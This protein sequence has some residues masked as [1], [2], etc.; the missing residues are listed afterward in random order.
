MSQESIN[1]ALQKTLFSPMTHDDLWS[2]FLEAFSYEINNMRNKYG[3]IKENWSI[4][5]F[6]KEDLI[7]IAQSFGYDPNLIIDNTFFMTKKEIESIPY[8]IREKTTY[9]GYALIFHQNGLLGDTFNY[10]YNGEKL[11]KSIDYDATVKNLINSNHYSPFIGI[12][13]I[14]NFS[15]MINSRVVM[16]D[17]IDNRGEYLPKDS[18]G[19]PT[20]SLDQKFNPFWKLDSS[21][22]KIPTKHLGIEYY[23][24]DWKSN[25][26]VTLG[27]GNEDTS[28]YSCFISSYE[29]YLKNSMEIFIDNKKL[30]ITIINID[31]KEYFYDDL[32]I[33]DSDNSYYDYSNGEVILT[34]NEIPKGL[35]INI[36][37]DLDL[38]VTQDYFY[39]LENGMEYNRRC[40]IIPHSGVFLTADIS[41]GKGSDFYK[42]N[43]EGYTV[44]DLKLKAQ[45]TSSY[46]REISL[47]ETSKLD[48]AMDADGNPSGL[49][50]YKLDSSIKWFLD[51]EILSEEEVANKIK[52]IACGNGKLPMINDEFNQMFNQR[53]L[54]A[55][56]NFNT[57]DNDSLIRDASTNKNNCVVVGN[58]T[59]IDGIINKSLD[60]NGSTYCYSQ[61]NLVITENTNYTLGIWFN[62]NKEP[63]TLEETIFDNFY[64]IEYDYANEQ[65]I[66]DDNSFSCSKNTNHFLCLLMNYS[67]QTT[68]VY[69]DCNLVGQFTYISSLVSDILYIGCDNTQNNCFYGIIDNVWLIINNLTLNQ[70]EYIYN[71]KI[72][73]ISHMGNRLGYYEI[74]S[75]EIFNNSDYM[76]IQSYVK[77]MDITNETYNIPNSEDDIISSQTRFYPIIE[78]YYSFTYK[79]TALKDVKVESNIEGQFYRTDTNEMLSGKI[80]FENGTWSLD[81]NTIKSKSQLEIDSPTITPYPNAWKV[82]DENTHDSTWY[83]EYDPYSSESFVDKII[84]ADEINSSQS[85]MIDKVYC[86]SLGGQ[87]IY[88]KDEEN[89][90]VY[91]NNIAYNLSSFFFNSDANETPLYS[92][93]DGN[94]VYV[95][96]SDLISETNQLKTFVDLGEATGTT[97][98]S[99][100]NGT[101]MYLNVEC[102]QDKQIKKYSGHIN[103]VVTFGYTLGTTLDKYYS[104]LSFTSEITFSDEP[105]STSFTPN[106]ITLRKSPLEIKENKNLNLQKTT[107]KYDEVSAIDYIYDFSK[108]ETHVPD[109]S[110][111]IVKGSITFNY[112]MNNSEGAIIKHTATVSEEGSISGANI[113]TNLSSFDYDTNVLTVK[114]INPINSKVVTS[115]EFYHSLDINTS[116][117]ITMNYKTEKSIKINEIGIEDE[118][119]ELI[120]YMTFN[121]IEFHSIYNNISA[122][123]AINKK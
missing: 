68:S 30:S 42:R 16:L 20:Y 17:Y 29:Y 35:E 82:T 73:L 109:P 31:N 81:K 41:Q 18:Y 100:N 84:H 51:S 15:T 25:Y 108:D 21:Y 80:D 98:Y 90:Y 39:Y 55:Y 40:P 47:S 111:E 32:N 28:V 99:K 27:I 22:I 88:S 83:S 117:P 61:S 6:D 7:R 116:Y 9:N 85:V 49:D 58:T 87:N 122:M 86:Y 96:M 62:A 44:P 70:M 10:Y 71:N 26:S 78:G 56:Y 46:N 110:I 59:K 115:Y 38:F 3:E 45:T 43:E 114:F 104:D 52:Y 107:E 76:I 33:L 103:D 112:W 74:A 123:F 66:I 19:V 67:T 94:S 97:L 65:I 95:T 105:D 12:I 50:N 75:D 93:N 63:S 72:S 79:N 34:F 113:N 14:K 121:D 64:K 60:F 37:Y 23:P 11:I 24:Q 2:Q 57:D 101:A 69:I 4:D 13:N 77:A 92:I 106:E 91:K 89:F 118:N 54:I 1:I 8:R 5:S 48:N 119:H 120:A 36:K 102:T 53:Y